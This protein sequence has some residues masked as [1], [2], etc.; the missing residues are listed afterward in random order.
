M[1][2]EAFRIGGLI[3][4]CGLML[5]IG[6]VSAEPSSPATVKIMQVRPYANSH[7]VY[8]HVSSG[9]LCSTSAFVIMTDEPGGKG[10]YA[11]ALTALT[12]GKRVI[13]EVSN[14]TGCTGWGTK[15]QSL[16]VLAN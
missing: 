5:L 10:M 13:L 2:R 3:G 12:T 4:L 15:L 11:A 7:S 8:I 16:Y 14:A 1:R 9:Q 6:A